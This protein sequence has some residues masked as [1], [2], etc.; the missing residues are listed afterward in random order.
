MHGL[1]QISIQ[2]L[3]A[4]QG[5][6]QS[7]LSIPYP[8]QPLSMQLVEAEAAAALIYVYWQLKGRINHSKPPSGKLH[9]NQ[10]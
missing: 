1:H 3:T 7:S 10:P 8:K 9:I 6:P 2:S 5:H 4:T